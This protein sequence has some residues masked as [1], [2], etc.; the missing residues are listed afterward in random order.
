LSDIVL[1][2]DTINRY[3]PPGKMKYSTYNVSC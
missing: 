2:G 1:K 3:N